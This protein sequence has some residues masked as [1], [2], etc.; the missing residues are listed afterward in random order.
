MRTLTLNMPKEEMDYLSIVADKKGVSKSAVM[1]QA[2][3]LYQIVDQ[4]SAH[5]QINGERKIIV[6][7]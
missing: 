2:L 3:R 5:I 4:K 7:I 6:A 1:K